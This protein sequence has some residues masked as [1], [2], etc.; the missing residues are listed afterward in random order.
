VSL[1][2]SLVTYVVLPVL[3]YR[4]TGSGLWTALVTAGEALPYLLFGLVAGAIADRTDRKRLM[5]RADLASAALLLTVPVAYLAGALTPLHVVAVGFGVQSLFVFFDA[6][7][8]GALPAIAGRHRLASAMSSL[9]GASTV[10]EV[11]LPMATG[12]VL[13]AVAPAPLLAVD[14]ASFI[15]SALLIRAV[16]RPLVPAAAGTGSRWRAEIGEGLRFLA[17]HPVVRV[18]TM[19]SVLACVSFGLF[20]GQ[21]VPWADRTLGVPPDDAR[22]GAL[23]GA[24]G[25]GGVVASV[26]YPGLARRFGEVHVMLAT[27][28]ACA[29]V[30]GLVAAS[31][32][33]CVAV[34]AIA[35][36]GVPVSLAILNAI[37]LRAK[38]T[39]DRLQSRVNTAGRMISF[40]LGTPVGAL[41]GGVLTQRYGPTASFVAAAVAQA[42]AA[43][44][45]WVSPLRR[46][47]RDP[48]MVAAPAE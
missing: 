12:A 42:A 10:L 20:G 27:M 16:R 36:W 7:N 6:A 30:G 39:P 28:P 18:Q 33:W 47:R 26:V 43:L 38:V 37:T 4:M 34:V 45:A 17:G 15:A 11:T 5:I 3:V 46:Y 25:L 1:G 35:V 2:G 22:L 23:F 44:V 24:W 14:A 31:R 13:A 19:I 32:T 29:A 48:A 40:G 9:H 41:V 21:L 8:F